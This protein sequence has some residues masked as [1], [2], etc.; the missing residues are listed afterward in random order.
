MHQ[1][2]HWL[3]A[4]VVDTLHFPEELPPY[5]LTWTCKCEVCIPWRSHGRG[6]GR[7]L[8]TNQAT[9]AEAVEANEAAWEQGSRVDRRGRGSTTRNDS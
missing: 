4:P 8:R 6:G 9:A 1:D 2:F 3:A 5:S 7:V